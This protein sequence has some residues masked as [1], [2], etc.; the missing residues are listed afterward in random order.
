MTKPGLENASLLFYSQLFIGFPDGNQLIPEPF[1]AKKANLSEQ[2]AHLIHWL[3]ANT[4]TDSG[5]S[6]S[7]QKKGEG[8]PSI[9]KTQHRVNV[10]AVK[11][12]RCIETLGKAYI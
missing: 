10:N 9:V 1:Q 11:K 4:V 2:S 7:N 5:I 6:P 8:V 3:E 12:N